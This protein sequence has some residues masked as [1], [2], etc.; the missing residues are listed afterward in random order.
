[1][2]RHQHIMACNIINTVLTGG[3]I[4]T[5]C[6]KPYMT[7]LDTGQCSLSM[8]QQD[9]VHLMQPLL[10]LIA[11]SHTKEALLVWDWKS[12][13][14]VIQ[15]ASAI[16]YSLWKWKWMETMLLLTLSVLNGATCVVDWFCSPQFWILPAHVTIKGRLV[17]IC[18]WHYQYDRILCTAFVLQMSD[19]LARNL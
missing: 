17:L 1:M 5:K 13:A 9:N 6:F 15:M 10:A 3:L 11:I 12:I 7:D 14:V 19:L 16:L 4:N 2:S 18:P 8:S